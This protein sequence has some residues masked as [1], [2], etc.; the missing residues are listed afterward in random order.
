MAEAVGDKARMKK[1]ASA[2]ASIQSAIRKLLWVEAAG[3]FKDNTDKNNTLLPQD[4]N[5]LALW[6]R[7]VEPNSTEAGRISR[8]LL[9]NWGKFGAS[10]PEWGGNIGTFPGSMEVHGHAWILQ[11][12]S[13]CEVH[14]GRYRQALEHRWL[15][16]VRTGLPGQQPASFTVGGNHIPL[17]ILGAKVQV[18]TICERRLPV[19]SQPFPAVDPYHLALGAP[20]S[21]Q[22][23]RV[24][25]TRA[26][27]F[28]LAGPLRTAKFAVSRGSKSHPK[29]CGIE[30]VEIAPRSRCDFDPLDT[31]NFARS[32][33]FGDRSRSASVN[34]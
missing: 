25:V 10:S 17:Q 27:R 12:L 22:A 32:C 6:F 20:W 26:M 28:S 9:G 30:R 2:A 1:Y 13:D 4:G 33:S 18:K 21:S 31:A 5:S 16:S 15:L 19:P 23:A 8:Y 24:K 14:L 29:V 3:A 11:E 7:V 34:H